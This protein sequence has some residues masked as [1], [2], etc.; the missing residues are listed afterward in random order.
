MKNLSLKQKTASALA[1]SMVALALITPSA[2][3]AQTAN[4]GIITGVVKNEKGEVVPNATVKAVNMGTNATR[5]ATTSGE[6]VYE[7]S[8]L[9]PG[10]REFHVR[11]ALFEQMKDDGFDVIAAAHDAGVLVDLWT[12]DAGTPRWRERL[13]RALDAGTDVVT[14]NTPREL[15]RA[16]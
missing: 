16:V 13:V 15:A 2:V 11:M 12:L 4:T 10:I 7:S 6:G 1:A 9:V 5:E 8:Q 14:T 3:L